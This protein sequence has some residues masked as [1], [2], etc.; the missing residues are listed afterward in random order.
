M[1]G[2][3]HLLLV[4]ILL[5]VTEEHTAVTRTE[6]VPSTMCCGGHAGRI[7]HFR[8]ERKKRIIYLVHINA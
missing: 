6:C 1:R 4:L 3:F 7:H 8:R 2:V 5:R